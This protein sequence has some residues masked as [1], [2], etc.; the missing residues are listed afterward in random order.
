MGITSTFEETK[1]RKLKRLLTLRIF[2]MLGMVAWLADEYG[3]A[4]QKFRL[5]HPLVWVWI[6]FIVVFGMLWQGIP[7][8]F[9]D[10]RY[11]IKHDTVW[12]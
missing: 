8:T 9:K 6:L 3:E 12:I 11:S 4:N 1:K 2:N 5:V 7:Q 10:I